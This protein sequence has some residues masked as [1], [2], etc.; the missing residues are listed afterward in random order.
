MQQ[1]V[2]GGRARIDTEGAATPVADFRR[3]FLSNL[4]DRRGTDL[5]FA[6]PNDCYLALAQTVRD[7]LIQRWLD[8]VHTGIDNQARF[9]AYLS[10]EYLVG[11]QLDNNLLNT[12]SEDVAR[13]ALADL[14]LS[15]D[16]LRTL[17]PEPGLGNG[18]LGRLAACY[19]D[20]LATLRIPSVGYGIR[21]EFGIFRQEFQD[22]WQVEQVDD[23]LTRGDPWEL[24]HP[25]M[26]VTVGFGGHTESGTD[27]D[28]RYQVRWVPE[29]TV[30]GVPYNLLVPGYR[31]GVVNTLRLWYARATSQLDLQTFNSGDY[32]RAVH[33]Q[34][35][36][37]NLTKVLYPEDSTAQG[38]Q[39]R[40]EQQYFFVACSLWDILRVVRISGAPIEQLADQVAIQLNDTHPSIGIVELMRLLI[41]AHGMGWDPAWAIASRVFAYTNHTLLPEALERWPTSLFARVLPRHLEII[42]EIN[43]RFLDEVRARFPGD[44]DRVRRLSIFEEGPEQRIRMA[45]LA[46][47]GSFAVNGVAPLQSRLLRDVVLRD[48]AELWPAKFLNVTNGVTPRRFLKLANPRLAQLIGRHIGEGWITDLD[49]LRRLEPLT[50]DPEFSAA[51][52]RVKRQNKQLLA[53]TI[54]DRVGLVVDPASLFDVMVKRLHEYKR[55]LLKVLH[56]ITLYH[57]L[58]ADPSSEPIAR[59]VIFGA[60]AAP[61]YRM[62]KLIVKLINE[63]ARVVNADP[64]VSERLQVVYLP[65]FNVSLGERIYPAANLSEQISLA[66]KEASGTGNMKLAL[67]GAVTIGT[68]DGANVEIRELV[69]EDNFFLFGLTAEEVVARKALGYRPATIADAN[70]TLRAVLDDIAS[71]RFSAGDPHVFQPIVNGLLTEDPYMLLADYQPYV[72]AQDAVGRAFDDSDRWTRMSILNAARCGYFSSDRAIREY[73]AEIWR[74]GPLEVERTRGEDVQPGQRLGRP[75]LADTAPN[76]WGLTEDEDRLLRETP[77]LV[78]LTM[79]N[80][81]DSGARGAL[82]ELAT[83]VNAPATMARFLASNRLVRT[84]AGQDAAVVET[85]EQLLADISRRYD[86]RTAD[87]R[88][89]F[90]D[91]VLARCRQAADLLDEKV[92]PDEAAEYKRWLLLVGERVAQAAAEH[93]GRGGP[94]RQ[95][96][97]AEA[98]TLR[99]V[100]AALCISG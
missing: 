34:V 69:G 80:A 89:D 13:E 76:P 46:C 56:V 65:N 8:T 6:T 23:W 19:L 39:L 2:S 99:D 78:G 83:A 22:G 33:N 57:R 5:S 43:R 55:Q 31:S 61:G 15:L 51:W 85:S 38:R 26:A 72:D 21:Y 1:P 71:G 28:G 70:P 35:L 54:R 94:L 93:D 53:L 44:E 11:K 4:H 73:C 92:M 9:V 68:L 98:A 87:G 25:E 50:D 79:L 18:G 88:D 40:L 64:V 86:L 75:P 84:L 67:N 59:T 95:V 24:P 41:D 14:G 77:I 49:Q 62:A 58:Q 37:E 12:D 81:S 96:S 45:H 52:R 36:S 32:V 100:A 97:D 60:K 82:L 3:A 42:Y 10:A 63:V 91:D 16:G 20:S 30:L 90:L 17:E 74:V 7:R 48:F 29:R 27:A 47:V 66:G